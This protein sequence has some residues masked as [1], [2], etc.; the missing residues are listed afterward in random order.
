MSQ[1]IFFTNAGLFYGGY[2]LASQ[3]N[4]LDLAYS[5]EAL[6]ETVFGT[7]GTRKFRG[8]LRAYEL[9]G[10]GFFNAGDGAVHNVFMDS[11]AVLDVG[12]ML[13][14]EDIVEGATATGSGYMF[15]AVE[16]KYMIGGQVGELLP[17]TLTASGRPAGP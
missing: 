8:G 5:V 9:S 13:F 17:F 4:K 2:A 15:R 6:D 11:H 16:L 12:V 14:A 3:F 1:N 7:D 10:G